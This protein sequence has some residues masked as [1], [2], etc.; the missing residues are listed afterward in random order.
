MTSQASGRKIA[1]AVLDAASNTEDASND[2][3]ETQRT[4]ERLD[5][6]G[7]VLYALRLAGIPVVST[8][9]VDTKRRET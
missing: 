5:V 6:L 2:D 4:M 7:T 1:E 8:T 3:D 9:S